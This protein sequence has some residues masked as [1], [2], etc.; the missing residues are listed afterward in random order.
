MSPT[1]R[2]F[3]IVSGAILLGCS[4]G[5]LY[6][7]DEDPELI[8][9]TLM[10]DEHRN[11][12]DAVVVIEDA[13]RRRAYP[14]IENFLDGP[15]PALALY[16]E[17]LTRDR[18]VDFFV[19]QAGSEAIAL[20]IL[21]YADR[22]NI[23]L[24]LAYGLVWGESRFYP[25]AVNRNATSI[26][27]G[28]FQ[29]NSLTFRHLT[30]ED[31]FNIDVNTYHGLKYLRFCL[32]QGE[33]DAQALAIYNAGLTRVIRGQTPASTLRYVDGVL[34]YQARLRARFREYILSH[35]PPTIA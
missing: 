2:L 11:R 34:S 4:T 22:L 10:A 33:N 25:V 24:T 12:R 17:P 14:N 7:P 13:E 18:V 5:Y 16:R 20:P 29:L 27:R 28:L 32:D 19:E 8:A 35:F 3:C 31:F 15:K 30:E 9:A 26:D 21:Y 1:T 23:S 6:I